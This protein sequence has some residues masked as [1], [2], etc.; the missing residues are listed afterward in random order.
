MGREQC[1]PP[2]THLKGVTGPAAMAPGL[3]QTALSR[4]ESWQGVL[5]DGRLGDDGMEEREKERRI[6]GRTEGRKEGP[7]MGGDRRGRLL[8]RRVACTQHTP[9]T[10][11]R[12]GHNNLPS[13]PYH[14]RSP[15]Q[16]NKRKACPSLLHALR[17]VQFSAGQSCHIPIHN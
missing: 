4:L 17:V 2:Y 7:L 12:K 1:L 5:R 8:S 6:G 16:A 14:A 11:T 10:H 9:H 13:N 3:D 15:G